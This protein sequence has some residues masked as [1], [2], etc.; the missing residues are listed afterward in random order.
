[1]RVASWM[2]VLCAVLCVIGVFLPSIQLR[3]GGAAV[4]KRVE[5]SL[6]KV[7]SD[8]AV[9]RRLI[10]VYRASHHRQLGADLVHGVSSRVGG[11]AR[12]ALDDARDALTAVDDVSDD[13]VRTA[14][15]ALVA[16][17]CALLGLDALMVALVFGELMRGSRRRGRYIVVV[18]ASVIAAAIAVALHLACREAVW[19]ANDEVGRSALSLGPGAYVLPIAALAAFALAV[20]LVARRSR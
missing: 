16:A 9:A 18:V 7:A 17:L 19:Q 10:A 15:I 20:L 11:R 2:F 4:S 1:V 13:D 6:Y 8:R 12:A 5:L 3:P 14:G